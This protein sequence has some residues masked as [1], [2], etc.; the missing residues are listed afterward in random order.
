MHSNNFVVSASQERSF[1]KNTFTIEEFE[2]A[3]QSSMSFEE[4]HE[5]QNNQ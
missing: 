4:A 5:F 2:E 3:D 1:L